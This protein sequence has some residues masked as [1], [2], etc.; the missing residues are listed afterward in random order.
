MFYQWNLRVFLSMLSLCQL[1][2]R[3]FALMLR[4]VS[5]Y[6]IFN[7]IAWLVWW[8]IYCFITMCRLSIWIFIWYSESS[9]HAN[10]SYIIM[11]IYLYLLYFWNSH[12]KIL[13]LFC[14]LVQLAADMQ[15]FSRPERLVNGPTITHYWFVSLF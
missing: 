4:V 13:L 7:A 8:N 5:P 6:Q 14:P 9:C 10:S 15:R 1:S 12:L 11:I 3:K 2:N